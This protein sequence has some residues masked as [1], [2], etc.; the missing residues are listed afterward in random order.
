VPKRSNVPV[1]FCSLH[2]YM[3]RKNNN[4]DS[5]NKNCLESGD[6][7]HL[8]EENSELLIE[9]ERTF[10]SCRYGHLVYSFIPG[11]INLSEF[12]EVLKSKVVFEFFVLSK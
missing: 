4:V 3:K 11:D 8:I 2:G 1:A 6:P 10:I 5:T 9:K 12:L 7:I